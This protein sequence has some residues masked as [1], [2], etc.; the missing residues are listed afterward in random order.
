M[1]VIRP[2]WISKEWFSKCPFN[3]CDHFGEKEMLA[4]VCKICAEDIKRIEKYKKQGRDPYDIKN[5][6]K[7]MAANFKKVRIMIEKDAKRFG[8]DL[9][10]IPD[11]YEDEAP[12]PESYPIFNLVRR[13]SNR[14]Q[15]II[16]QLQ[17]I[18]ID[19]DL[20]LV[21]KVV[22][23]LS[24][25]RHF[26][27]AKTARALNSRFEE[28]K[29]PFM[30]ELADSKTAAFFAYVAIERNSRALRALAKHKPLSQQKEKHLKQALISLHMAEMIR[31][32][33]FKDYDL[34]YKEFG[35]EEYDEYFGGK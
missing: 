9:N 25:S 30:E 24:H 22:D 6:V 34:T 3:Y 35:C 29:D 19:T 7:D 33:F 17:V 26:I 20:S 8:I 18:P 2:P 5:V 21:E 16:D 11:D 13:Y 27:I 10:D 15:K 1:G 28:Q 31:E 32:D 4:H 23:V 12:E 14:I